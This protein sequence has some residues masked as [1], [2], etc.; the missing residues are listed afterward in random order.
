MTPTVNWLW[1]WIALGASASMIGGCMWADLYAPLG[2]KIAV[3]TPWA[4]FVSMN[5][6]WA[7]LVG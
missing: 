4:W 6:L 2:V 1:A 7:Y 3:V 5:P